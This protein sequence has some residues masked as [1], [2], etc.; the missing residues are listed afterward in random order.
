[1]DFSYDTFVN[2]SKSIRLLT[3]VPGVDE[4]TVRCMIGQYK[5]PV[6]H[7]NQQCPAYWSISYTWF[8]V[9]PRQIIELNGQPL[10][11]GYNLWLFLKQLR[12]AGQ[13]GLLWVDAL[14]INQVN[15]Y[16]KN[17]QVAI[18]RHIYYAALQVFAWLG[19]ASMGMQSSEMAL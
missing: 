15:I 10:S 19:E 11:I 4:A 13:R 2:P 7:T 6:A 1:M 16:D 5:S 17:A 18:M 14:C 12:R 3:I 9:D 8:P